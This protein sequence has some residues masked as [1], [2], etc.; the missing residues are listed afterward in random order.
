[1]KKIY[2]VHGWTYTLD[3]W[4]ECIAGLKAAGFDPVMLR[5]PGL[6][7]PSEKVWTLDQ[8]VE[9][10]D[11]VLPLSSSTG[12]IEPITLVAH[13]NGGRVAIALAAQNPSRISN[14][15]LVDAAG[16]VHNE[17]P[18]RMKRAV[19]GTIAKTGKKL[20]SN[21]LIRKIF[22]KLIVARDYA[23]AP[24]NMRET[25]KNLISIDLTDRLS[26]ITA[27]TLILWGNHD[28]ATPVMDAHLMHKRILGSK[29]V[30]FEGVGHSPH[31][32]VPERVVE[33]ITAWI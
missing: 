30:V 1:M 18:I 32:D 2:I 4:D 22:H 23:R 27:K 15:I 26:K 11:S 14:L 19:F 17:M 9:W 12:P 21:A 29:L 16:I 13:S 24:E 31:K 7:A 10:L 25:M 28:K 5:V 8:Y 20:T 3:A 33:E 6:T